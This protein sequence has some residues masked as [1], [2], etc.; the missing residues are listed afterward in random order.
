[1]GTL[2]GKMIRQVTELDDGSNRYGPCEKCADHVKRTWRI[3]SR[4]EYKRENG[5]LY[6]SLYS[7][8]YGH[9]NCMEDLQNA[10]EKVEKQLPT[11]T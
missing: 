11:Q 2:T 8:S 10:Q 6:S 7:S 5:E 3:D 9:K 1:M 4:I